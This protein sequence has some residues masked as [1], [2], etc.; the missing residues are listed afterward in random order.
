[1]KIVVPIMA[2]H[3]GDDVEIQREEVVIRFE[4]ACP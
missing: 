2:R 4:E 3:S 1:M